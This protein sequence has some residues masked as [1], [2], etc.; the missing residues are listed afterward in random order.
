MT[1]IRTRSIANE[2]EYR[3]MMQMHGE[4]LT[5]DMPH[6]LDLRMERQCNFSDNEASDAED[7]SCMRFAK[8]VQRKIS[9][10]DHVEVCLIP[11]LAAL[12]EAMKRSMWYTREEFNLMRRNFRRGIM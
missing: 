1:R 6:A 9:F 2:A 3:Q 10:E 4:M 7:H 11:S 12:D 8:K 5:V